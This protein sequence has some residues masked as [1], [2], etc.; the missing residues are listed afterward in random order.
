M[1][2]GEELAKMFVSLFAANILLKFKVRAGKDIDKIDMNG[3]AGL[4]L[5]PPDHDLIFE[6]R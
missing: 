3:I 2:L 5:S 6:K 1:C 4:T